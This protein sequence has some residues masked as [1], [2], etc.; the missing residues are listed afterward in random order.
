MK[1]NE[2]T[3]KS[4]CFNPFQSKLFSKTK[5]LKI[6]CHADMKESGF[7][8]GMI[9]SFALVVSGEKPLRFN[10]RQNVISRCKLKG[11]P[12]VW[13]SPSTEMGY[14]QPR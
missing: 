7:Q 8:E 5:R 6:L 9:I 14:R 2:K 3:H 11:K 10:I 13:I 12:N 4:L 1:D